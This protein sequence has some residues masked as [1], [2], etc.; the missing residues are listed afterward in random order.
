M[1]YSSLKLGEESWAAY[2]EGIRKALRYLRDTDFTD[3][4]PG[5][6]SIQGDDIYALVQSIETKTIDGKRPE[7]HKEYLDVQYI[8]CGEEKMG[9]AHLNEGITP[10]E[11]NEVKDIAFFSEAPGEQFVICRDK[12]FCVFFPSDIHR[13]GCCVGQ[14][15]PVR[16]VV[17]KV[18]MSAL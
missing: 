12:D 11:E 16:K 3:K 10:A 13:P 7:T 18:R 5:C 8:I 6:Y 1:I 4:E 2:P 14:P 15:S 17:V 9:Y